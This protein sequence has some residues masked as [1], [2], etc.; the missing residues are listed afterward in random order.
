VRPKGLGKFKKLILFIGSRTRY[1]PDCSIVSQLLRYSVPILIN[2]EVY[3]RKSNKLNRETSPEG[4]ENKLFKVSCK[5]DDR[6]GTKCKHEDEYVDRNY[7]HLRAVHR[8][9]V[10]LSIFGMCDL[11]YTSTKLNKE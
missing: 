3:Y 10:V 6:M 8:S 1:L 9:N 4:H 7:I 5:L 2:G 11:E